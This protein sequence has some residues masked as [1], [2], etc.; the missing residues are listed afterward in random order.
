MK[1]SPPLETAA[2]MAPKLLRHPYMRIKNT[3]IFIFDCRVLPRLSKSAW[4]G[5]LGS[6]VPQLTQLT[7]LIS[8]SHW[9][10]YE[11]VLVWGIL[12]GNVA[13]MSRHVGTTRRVA[14]I[15]ARWVHVADTKLKMLWQ[16][17]SA[18]ANIS[19]IFPSAYVEIYYG[20]GVH[21]HRYYCTHMLS[22]LIS[23]FCCFHQDH[24]LDRHYN[25]VRKPR[26]KRA[27]ALSTCLKVMMV[28][29]WTT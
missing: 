11:L 6:M 22:M 26:S 5:G 17:V 28:P 1:R 24:V 14:P 29:Y 18:R 8:A 10:T 7:W 4:V 2:A 3:H 25:N 23:W 13:N 20:M 12:A 19:Q 21:T 9:P 27:H 16:F 15:L